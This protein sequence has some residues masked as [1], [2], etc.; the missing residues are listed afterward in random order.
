MET[1]DLFYWNSGAIAAIMAIIGALWA[2]RLMRSAETRRAL[3]DLDK[4]LDAILRTDH[5]HVADF[6]E[7]EH[8]LRLFRDEQVR[9]STRIEALESRFDAHRRNGGDPT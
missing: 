4:K 5:V 1:H 8:D 9:N 3:D 6:K 2:D 7:V